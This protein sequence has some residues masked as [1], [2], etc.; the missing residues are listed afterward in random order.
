M[1]S[2]EMKYKKI[3]NKNA[4]CC[5]CKKKTNLYQVSFDTGLT[6]ASYILCGDCIKKLVDSVEDITKDMDT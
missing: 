4:R 5:S 6:F 3:D 2:Y 1:G